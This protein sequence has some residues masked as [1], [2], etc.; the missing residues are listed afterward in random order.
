MV[1]VQLM[2]LNLKREMLYTNKLQKIQQDIGQL[3]LTNY[4]GI[5]NLPKL[6]IQVTSIYI[7]GFP[8]VKSISV[9][10]VWID[11]LLKVVET[12]FAF[13]K[14]VFTQE[15]KEPGLIKKFKIE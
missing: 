11:M 9:T 5:K 12:I 2:I 13:L 4:T 7:D 3:K 15:P 10:T 6:L 8:M 1:I 14:T